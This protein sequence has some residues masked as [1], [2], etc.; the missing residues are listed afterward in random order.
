MSQ[1]WL[2]Q[3]SLVYT[4]LIS[5]LLLQVFLQVVGVIAVA[6]LIIPWILVP[7]FPLLTVFLFLRCYFLQTS[8][9]I[10][11]LEATSNCFFSGCL[12]WAC[13]FVIETKADHRN[14]NRPLRK[15]MLISIKAKGGDGPW[16][17][18]TQFPREAGVRDITYKGKYAKWAQ[19][20]HFRLQFIY[21]ILGCEARKTEGNNLLGSSEKHLA[22]VEIRHNF[23]SGTFIGWFSRVYSTHQTPMYH[24]L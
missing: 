12:G 9:D 15:A 3:G 13:P 4:V 23:I 10:K 24:I 17:G 5:L 6:A 11:R 1:W 18:H 2:T 21:F 14:A 8:R 16:L 7:V 19:Q 22:F 20:G